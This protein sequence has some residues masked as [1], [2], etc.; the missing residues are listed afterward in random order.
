MVS[1]DQ[2]SFRAHHSPAFSWVLA[3]MLSLIVCLD[4]STA[5]Q[6]Q[7]PGAEAGSSDAAASLVVKAMTARQMGRLDLA[8]DFAQN[9]SMVSKDNPVILSLLSKLQA[10]NG[11][12][13]SGLYFARQAMSLSPDPNYAR[14]LADLL[15]AHSDAAL[16]AELMDKLVADDPSD[17]RARVLR[18]K[19][20][21]S[22]GQ[23]DEVHDELAEIDGGY[24]GSVAVLR[25]LVFVATAAKDDRGLSF[26]YEWISQDPANPEP[27]IAAV[28]L[29][30]ALG[31]TAEAAPL[32]EDSIR[33]DPQNDQLAALRTTNPSDGPR[34]S[35]GD[36][37][38]EVRAMLLRFP[39]DRERLTQYVDE[40]TSKW[41]SGTA[42]SS[43][44]DA[45]GSALLRSSAV[46]KALEVLV[47]QLQAD[48]TS[49]IRWALV[50]EGQRRR[51]YLDDAALTCSDGQ[52]FFPGSVPLLLQCSLIAFDHGEVGEAER[53][54][55]LARRYADESPPLNHLEAQL[56][57]ASA[58]Q[59]ANR[60]DGDQALTLIVSAVRVNPDDPKVLAQA[61]QVY[62]LLGDSD[63]ALR[64]AR[65]A[66]EADPS[67][68]EA[69]A[70]AGRIY[71]EAKLYQE[72]E[73]ALSA[74]G[75]VQDSNAAL[76][77]LIG[78][79]ASQ[80]G[81]FARSQAAYERALQL[82]PTNSVLRK[83]L[84]ALSN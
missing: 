33:L 45:L 32:L 73:A 13:E 8:I 10:E 67:S 30:L 42:S 81:A 2:E 21:L 79:A 37:A 65:S 23:L 36:P 14:D 77:E 27:R 40:L 58:V 6:L 39:V 4:S 48:V 1:F 71:M 18:A 54:M 66:V 41:Q 55:Q 9:A 61:A 52:L 50:A 43:D 74:A 31:R 15:I 75:A 49:E 24:A 26:A 29:L 28:R 20:R 19:A 46:A 56:E 53:L 82:E 25:D 63:G 60:G 3:G 7:D 68:D 11:D 84:D 17:I 35:G 69:Q 51:S 62:S 34:P 5:Q 12:A 78:D 22:L 16:A 38:S 76:F 59:A 80:L 64:F 83:K 70:V 72:A 44:I 57:I 47:P